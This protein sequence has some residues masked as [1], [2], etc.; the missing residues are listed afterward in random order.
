MSTVSNIF[1]ADPTAKTEHGEW[2]NFF[3]LAGELLRAATA[4][5][6]ECSMAFPLPSILRT[7][8]ADYLLQ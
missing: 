7:R 5:S 8:R 1:G 6:A 4:I 3:R 2:P